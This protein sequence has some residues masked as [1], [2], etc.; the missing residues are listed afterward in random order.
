MRSSRGRMLRL[1]DRRRLKR[2]SSILI[3]AG[4]LGS[5][6][7]GQMPLGAASGLIPEQAADQ[8]TLVF[9]GTV[10]AAPGHQAEIRV[11]F[12]GIIYYATEPPKNIGGRVMPDKQRKVF[13]QRFTLDRYA[14]RHLKIYGDLMS[15]SPTTLIPKAP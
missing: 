15:F 5:L 11:P 10:V 4:V 9:A 8:D 14:D 3:A 1:C 7:S 2:F 13:H 12:T 6:G